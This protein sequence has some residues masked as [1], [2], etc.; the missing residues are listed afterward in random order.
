M[1]CLVGTVV[2]DLTV[3]LPH[4]NCPHWAGSW[5]P[6]WLDHIFRSTVFG[7][8]M[9]KIRHGG[10]R[11]TVA[12]W[13]FLEVVRCGNG[14]IRHGGGHRMVAFWPFLE[15]VRCGVFFWC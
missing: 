5:R 4:G 8:V 12:F 2:N 1:T 7:Q 14:Q 3:V 13:P 9:A 15:V 6:F 10:G 11:H